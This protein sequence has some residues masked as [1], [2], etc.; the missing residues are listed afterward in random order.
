[1][2]PLRSWTMTRVLLVGAGSFLF[3]VVLCVVWIALQ[4]T[5]A[6]DVGSGGGGIGAASVGI[7]AAML[8]I[9]FLPPI[10][11]LVLWIKA[12]RSSA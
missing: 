9:P 1:M 3:T 4:A 5:W 6:A 11:L 2:R 10:V 7:S 8:A 12:R